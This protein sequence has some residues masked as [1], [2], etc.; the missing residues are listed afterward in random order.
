MKKIITI[1]C[2]SLFI[3]T[4]ALAKDTSESAIG[5]FTSA[6]QTSLVFD[7]SVEKDGSKIGIKGEVPLN[8]TAR[9]IESMN[10]RWNNTSKSSIQVY[11]QVDIGYSSKHN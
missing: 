7:Q 4:A 6:G 10:Q 2:L 8:N 1:T 9:A 3:S 11:G 5:L